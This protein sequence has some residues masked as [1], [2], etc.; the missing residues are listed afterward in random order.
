MN[1]RKRSIISFLIFA[2]GLANDVKNKR[3]DIKN[4]KREVKIKKQKCGCAL[5]RYENAYKKEPRNRTASGFLCALS[6]DLQRDKNYLFENW[7]AR[8]A[9]LRPYFLRSF[10]L[11]SRVRKPAFL[12]AG[13]RASSYCKRARESP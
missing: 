13:R 7:G 12:R 3:A 8:R 1:L 10:I 2:K 4:Q 6:I 9:A 11:G 5:S